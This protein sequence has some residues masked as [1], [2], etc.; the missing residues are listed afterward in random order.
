M[1]CLGSG[2]NE[3]AVAFPEAGTDGELVNGQGFRRR[4]QGEFPAVEFAGAGAEEASMK[5]QRCRGR[6]GAG[7]FGVEGVA[8]IPPLNEFDGAGQWLAGEEV[9]P[10]E[11]GAG[12]G[13]IEDGGEAQRFLVLGSWFLV[14]AGRGGAVVVD[15]GEGH[16]FEAG[17]TVDYLLW[18]CVVE[19]SDG[20]SGSEAAR[21]LLRPAVV[22]GLSVDVGKG[23]AALEEGRPGEGD[24]GKAIGAVGVVEEVV[25]GGMRDE[26]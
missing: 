22:D 18:R 17:N 14:V 20:V 21:K 2:L 4:E 7:V 6:L 25:H 11:R 5:V 1:R 8:E 24:G 15:E 12:V 23:D 26:G 19:V 16:G 10:G 3:E 13:E 9:E